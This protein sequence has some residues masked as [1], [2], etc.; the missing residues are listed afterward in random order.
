MID[1]NRRRREDEM[2]KS[3]VTVDLGIDEEPDGLIR[4][5]F[6]ADH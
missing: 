3:M 4:K 2:I 5:L 6:N 1:D